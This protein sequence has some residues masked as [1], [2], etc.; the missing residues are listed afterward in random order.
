MQS[1]ESDFSPYI[2]DDE[3]F[4]SYCK[5]MNKVVH[6]QLNHYEVFTYLR[7]HRGALL[8]LQYWLFG[9][10][11]HH[12]EV[13]H[14]ESRCWAWSNKL[15]VSEAADSSCPGWML[16]WATRTSCSHQIEGAE[17]LCTSRW[18][19][20]LDNCTWL[21]RDKAGTPQYSQSKIHLNQIH[22]QRKTLTRRLCW[23]LDL[24]VPTAS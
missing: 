22:G 15:I 8:S 21:S 18:S 9:A 6:I 10:F 7:V 5:R 13:W 14:S 11:V 23:R 19:T 20:Q 17:N 16:G 12:Y 3:S 1:H 24:V 4:P 2:E